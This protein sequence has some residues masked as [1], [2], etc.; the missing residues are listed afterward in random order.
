M[1]HVSRS[2]L[3]GAILLTSTPGYGQVLAGASLWLEGGAAFQSR[4]DVRIPS[5]TGTEFSIAD[6]HRG[7]FFAPRLYLGYRFLERHE[8]RALYAPLAFTITERF[9]APVVFQGETYA[10]GQNVKTYYRFNSYRLT[11]RYQLL[12]GGDFTLKAG[13]T[14]KI[15][16]AE[17]KLSQGQ[18]SS[19]RDN[20]GLV[21]LLHLHAAYAL[22][23]QVSLALDADA[24]AAPQGRAEDAA[25]LAGFQAAPWV[26]VLAGYRTVEGG[27]D[28]AGGVYNFTWIHYA[29]LGAAIEF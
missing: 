13:F 4:N 11:Y 17:I 19:K 2:W 27:A 7:P 16:D 1:M 21:P 26:R 24:L 3:A 20:V 22:T 29:V 23:D 10:V 14:A 25:L 12:G 15:R 18:R 5:D 9:P 6:L 8:L 28:G